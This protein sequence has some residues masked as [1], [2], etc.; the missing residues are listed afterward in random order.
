MSKA[1]IVAKYQENTSWIEQVPSEWQRYIV[2]KGF[3]ME[4]YGREPYSYLWWI[5]EHYDSLPDLMVFVQGNPFDHEPGLLDRL[6]TIPLE[7]DKFSWLG[8]DVY[9][10]NQVGSPQ[11]S[12]PIMPT[13]WSELFATKMPER[14]TFHRGCHFIVT[15][16]ALL[17]RPLWFYAKMMKLIEWNEKTAW[18]YERL[19]DHIFLMQSQHLTTEN[20]IKTN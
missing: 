13:V 5:L 6:G 8:R 17:S 7:T 14:L 11:D 19:W 10:C 18:C 9:S 16:E 4:N 15:K 3:H 20:D 2:E 12:L 1:I